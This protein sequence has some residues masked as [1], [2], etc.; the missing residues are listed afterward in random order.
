MGQDY[1]AY[2]EHMQASGCGPIERR[3]GFLLMDVSQLHVSGY[4]SL[5]FVRQT[6]GVLFVFWLKSQVG[7]KQ[8]QFYG[9]RPIPEAVTKTVETEMNQEW[10]HVAKFTVRG[11]ELDIELKK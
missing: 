6:D 2:R 8:W 5:I 9:P 4:S 10:G 1:S 11:E 7:E 3:D